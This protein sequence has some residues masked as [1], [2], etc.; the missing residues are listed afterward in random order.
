MA[1][2]RVFAGISMP[3]QSSIPR[4][5]TISR[6]GTIPR[7]G[8]IT[9]TGTLPWTE[10]TH[11]FRSTKTKHRDFGGFPMPHE[12]VSRGINHFFPNL[13]R[14]FTR[15]VTIP[16]T[17]TIA[18]QHAGPLAPGVHAVPYI[19]F[20]AIVGRNSD[21]QELTRDQ[22]EELGGVEYRGLTALLWI[23]AGVRAFLA[24]VDSILI[25]PNHIVSH[26]HPAHSIHC[27]C[28]IHVY[29]AMA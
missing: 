20:E 12:I 14:T 18:S 1:L 29:L 27:H 6:T 21:F 13:K 5:T 16:R 26:R 23:V 7:T 15:T 19:T 4:T 8:T 28:P 11:T 17:H 10:T 22:L 2:S 24:L 9:R 25:F 3:R